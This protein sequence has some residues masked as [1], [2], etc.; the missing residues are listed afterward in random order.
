[1]IFFCFLTLAMTWKYLVLAPPFLSQVSLD[2]DL[3][4]L[5][6]MAAN[7]MILKLRVEIRSPSSGDRGLD[8][9]VVSNW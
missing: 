1:V 4:L 5:F 3:A 9:W 8:S 2:F 7:P 6:S